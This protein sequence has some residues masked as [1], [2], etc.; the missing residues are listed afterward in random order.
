MTRAQAMLLTILEAIMLRQTLST[1]AAFLAGTLAIA[2]AL[3]QDVTQPQPELQ[4]GQQATAPPGQVVTVRPDRRPYFMDRDSVHEVAGTY[5][6]EDG[7]RAIVKDR[8]RKLIVDYDDRTTVLE[9][10]GPNLFSSSNDD[11]TV[12]FSRDAFGD[13]MIVLS[14]IPAR[15]LAGIT[16]YGSSRAE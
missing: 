12:K 9:A 11:M 14:Y 1:A 13:D 10:I 5:D 3:A 7:S 4:T 16:T 6:M 15:R 8:N 2:P